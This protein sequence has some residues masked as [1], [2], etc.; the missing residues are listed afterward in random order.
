MKIANLKFKEGDNALISFYEEVEGQ[1]AKIVILSKEIKEKNIVETDLW[2][3]CELAPMKDESKGY[4]AIKADLIVNTL[5][6]DYLDANINVLVDG[7]VHWSWK[8]ASDEEAIKNII[9]EITHEIM[10][11]NLQIKESFEDV[12]AWLQTLYLY[13][14]NKHNEYLKELADLKKKLKSE[15]KNH[16]FTQA[17][18]L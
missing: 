4:I 7:V 1:K 13:C 15:A 9:A 5:K 12:Q 14:A 18:R 10:E 17:I 2:Y 3:K 6:I 8:S 11:G 16:V